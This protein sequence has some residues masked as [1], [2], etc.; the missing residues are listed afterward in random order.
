MKLFGA[1]HGRL[2]KIWIA[3]GYNFKRF[4]I[5]FGIDRYSI[6]LDLGPFWLSFEL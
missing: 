6:N 4:A 2:G 5:G 1:G 3:V